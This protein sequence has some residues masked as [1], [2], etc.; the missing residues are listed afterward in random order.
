MS[1]NVIQ[2]HSSTEGRTSER[3]SARASN[4]TDQLDLALGTQTH[5]DS[6]G[7]ETMGQGHDGASAMLL[8]GLG[9]APLSMG[10][11]GDIKRV[12]TEAP[13]PRDLPEEDHLHYVKSKLREPGFGGHKDMV[14]LAETAEINF[15]LKMLRGKHAATTGADTNDTPPPPASEASKP[16]QS[17]DA[18]QVVKFIYWKQDEYAAPWLLTSCALFKPDIDKKRGRKHLERER[19][20][21]WASGSYIEYT[22][23]ELVQG[24]LDVWMELASIARGQYSD[25]E[26]FEKPFESI[27][28]M[29]NVPAL[30][31][32]CSTNVILKGLG[33]NSSGN[34]HRWFRNAVSRLK[35]AN[36]EL[37]SKGETGHYGREI[38]GALILFSSRETEI[39]TRKDGSQDQR[40]GD[41]LL[42]LNLPVLRLYLRGFSRVKKELRSELNSTGKWLQLFVKQHKRGKNPVRIGEELLQEKMG[43][44]QSHARNFRRAISQCMD[45]LF[46]QKEVSTALKAKRNRKGEKV[47]NWWYVYQDKETGQNRYQLVFFP[48]A[49][50]DD[51]EHDLLG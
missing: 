18:K 16:L 11:A 25:F 5:V 35:S 2:L 12:M 49:S 22:G 40:D 15:Q 30:R 1:K 26:L 46:K 43:L 28:S 9:G 42:W 10:L 50:K 45:Q 29:Q 41:H 6:T 14:L 19:L 13:P 44:R 36:M 21:T 33:K 3:I 38:G 8:E 31:I 27:D 32:R 51:S 23:P 17:R 48:A 34:N 47:K 37:F 7:G 20:A 4:G 24:D 39:I